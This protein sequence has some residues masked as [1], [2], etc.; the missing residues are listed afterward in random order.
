MGGL[1]KG[2]SKPPPAKSQQGQGLSG[3]FFSRIVIFD[4]GFV[5]QHLQACYPSLPISQ[6]L[7]KP[8]KPI[9]YSIA[10]LI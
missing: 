9:A 6:G 3:Q 4:L 5:A 7:L 10:L 1:Q 8:F 2:N